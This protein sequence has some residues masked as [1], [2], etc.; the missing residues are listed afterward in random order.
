MRVETNEQTIYTAN[1]RFDHQA[2]L[3][4]THTHKR[5][6]SHF[7]FNIEYVDE[8][9]EAQNNNQKHCTLYAIAKLDRPKRLGRASK[10]GRAG[11]A[12]VDN[13][14]MVFYPM[15]SLI[16]HCVYRDG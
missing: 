15:L 12:F 14:I 9:T 7:I 8:R 11:S 13:T 1:V 5:T 2:F 10:A 6:F 16:K 3:T 4:H